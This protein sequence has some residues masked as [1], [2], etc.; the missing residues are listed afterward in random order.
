[1][2]R[3]RP[4][5]IISVIPLVFLIIGII[6][7]I[8]AF[9]INAVQD[10]TQI[11]LLLSGIVAI[12]LSLIS[13]RRK[14]SALIL[15][16]RKSASQVLPTVPI[17]LMIATVSAT[18]MLSGVVPTLITYGLK[19]LNP[20]LFLC[21]ACVVCAIISVLSGSSWTTI[22]TIGVAFM[23]I[24]LMWGF[25]P[26]W[27]AGAII[28]GAYFGDKISPLSDT[29]VLASSTCGVPMLQHIANMMLTTVPAMTVAL[30]VFTTAG[31]L[32]DTGTGE[33]TQDIIDALNARF[34]ITP[35]VLLIPLMTIVVLVAHVGTS[36]TLLL[37]TL[38]GLIGIFVFQG[39]LFHMLNSGS[40]SLWDKILTTVKLLCVSTDFNT[41]NSTLDS[42]ISTGGMQGMLPTIY[43]ILCAMIFGGAMLGTGMIFTITHSITKR[44]KRSKNIVLATVCT[45]ITL[46]GCTSDQYLSIILNGNLFRNIYRRR[47]LE[48]KLLSR[49]IED[50]TSVTS[51]LIPWNSCGLTQSTVLG[52]STFTYLPY[53]IFNLASPAFTLLFAWTGFK[54]KKL[55]TRLA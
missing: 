31:I 47:N 41:G 45:G 5:L 6:F 39:D 3:T 43:L 37:S 53:C 27:T 50:S 55:K 28:S 13:C 1:M 12:V 24:G 32:T 51:V 2:A 20:T 11:L 40:E 34:N 22:A 35:W 44:L 52:V 29:T 15:G 46:N 25:S 21:T 19:I 10:Y 8:F 54:L 14:K 49:S 48:P 33:H 36:L 26:G 4:S 7:I 17:L 16:L 23:G 30:I 18:W 9:G 38:F 42:L